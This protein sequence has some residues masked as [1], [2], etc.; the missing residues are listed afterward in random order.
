MVKL[1]SKNENVKTIFFIRWIFNKY[2]KNLS[3]CVVSLYNFNFK[4]QKSKQ[5][6]FSFTFAQKLYYEYRTHAQRKFPQ[7]HNHYCY[8]RRNGAWKIHVKIFSPARSQGCYHQ[9]Q[10]RSA[11]E[12][13]G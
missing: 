3:N 11:E 1:T 2:K 4:T 12:N 5:G 8:R 9:P 10:G 13:C 6:R 7:R